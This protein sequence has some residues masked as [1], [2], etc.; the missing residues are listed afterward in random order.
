MSRHV[1]RRGSL[2]IA[3]GYDDGMGYF[4]QVFDSE[5]ESDENDDG[6]ILNEGFIEGISKERML[7]LMKQYKVDNSMHTE[8]IELGIAI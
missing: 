1:K 7:E 5:Q 4:F 3:Y 6:L 8:L 2:E